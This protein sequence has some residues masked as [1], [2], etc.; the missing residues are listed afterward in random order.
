MN[1]NDR[2]SCTMIDCLSLFSSRFA[3]QFVKDLKFGIP[4]IR[5]LKLPQSSS[6]DTK[7]QFL[8]HFV[9][10]LSFLIIDNHSHAVRSTKLI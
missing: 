10:F 6:S 7:F 9:L 1:E 2:E 5:K 3:R 4:E 8:F